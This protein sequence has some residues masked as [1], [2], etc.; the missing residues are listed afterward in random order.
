MIEDFFDEVKHRYINLKG[1]SGDQAIN[2]LTS[3]GI[4]P[5][6]AAEHV[7]DSISSFCRGGLSV[8]EAYNIQ[9]GETM[10]IGSCLYDYLEIKYP[11]N[12]PVQMIIVES[13]IDPRELLINFFSDNPLT[14]ISLRDLLTP[15]NEQIFPGKQ[16]LHDKLTEFNTT[17]L[18]PLESVWC[19]KFRNQCISIY[20]RDD[21]DTV[22]SI[23]NYLFKKLATIKWLNQQTVDYSDAIK[24]CCAFCKSYYKEWD[25]GLKPGNYFVRRAR[26][27]L[28][29]I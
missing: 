22:I 10:F 12:Y 8:R 26:P 20:L 17:F 9:R 15:I 27:N 16:I 2:H 28:V 25:L 29:S 6:L 14:L 5:E 7:T 3:L 18:L 13:F 19:E 21:L 1:M 4:H 24:K 11:L 23:V